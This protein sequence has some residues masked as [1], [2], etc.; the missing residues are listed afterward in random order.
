VRYA[1]RNLLRRP[2]F[3]MTAA[4]TLALG[5]GAN[6]A[7]FSVVNAYLFRPFPS[8][9]A[10]RL[11]VI[12]QAIAGSNIGASISYPNYRE[13]RA[14]RSVLEDSLTYDNELVN[15]PVPGGGDCKLR[16]SVMGA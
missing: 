16:F 13:I 2:A 5:I 7:I 8:P 15:L 1:V 9:V 11:V 14:Q 10:D 4:L 12:A 3:T 6:T